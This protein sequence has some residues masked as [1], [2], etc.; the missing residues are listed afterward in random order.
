MTKEIYTSSF[1]LYLNLIKFLFRETLSK[2]KITTHL[3]A[4]AGIVL[5]SI[6]NMVL[7]IKHNGIYIQQIA[8]LRKTTTKQ[9][10]M[11]HC[12]RSVLA[13]HLSFAPC[14]YGTSHS[15]PL[16]A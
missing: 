14:N 2:N 5:F 12:Q 4:C 13:I 10:N 6:T 1:M 3:K 7:K 8:N 9:T 15:T 16:L 11:Q